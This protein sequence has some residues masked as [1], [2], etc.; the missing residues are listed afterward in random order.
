[1]YKSLFRDSITPAGLLKYVHM[2][3][4]T[5]WT[6]TSADAFIQRLPSHIIP[7]AT[8]AE[9]ALTK[10]STNVVQLK[11]VK[12][13]LAFNLTDAAT[14]QQREIPIRIDNVQEEQ[15]DNLRIGASAVP[16]FYN[17]CYLRKN[18]GDANH[19][20]DITSAIDSPLNTPAHGFAKIVNSHVLHMRSN[21]SNITNDLHLN[22]ITFY[23]NEFET[24]CFFEIPPDGI[25]AH[26]IDS[27]WCIGRHLMTYLVFTD[28]R[29]QGTYFANSGY[30]FTVRGTI[31]YAYHDIGAIKTY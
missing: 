3:I 25:A 2:D 11:A 26:Q 17:N 6:K 12:M 10:V 1:M 31:T 14:F 13:R 28:S 5:T 24:D 22:P 8:N 23:E 29:P 27:L 20:L 18:V 21:F 16:P 15:V 7:L 19:V 4:N 30:A 9:E